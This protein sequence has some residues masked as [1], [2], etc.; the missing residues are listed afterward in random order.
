M[1]VVV[2]GYFQ[3]AYNVYVVHS[4]RGAGFAQES[5]DELFVFGEFFGQDFD[6]HHA[7]H[8]FLAGEKDFAHAAFPEFFDE[9]IA[10]DEF[11]GLFPA[12]LFKQ[13][14]ELAAGQVF[15]FDQKFA[16][17]DFGAGF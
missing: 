1:A 7:V 15:F 4:A 17:R 3:A 8:G 10:G 5:L 12:L 13:G 2:G 11:A 9:F 6:R 14:F 16:E